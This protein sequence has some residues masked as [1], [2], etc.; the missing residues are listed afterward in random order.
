MSEAFGHLSAQMLLHVLLMNA[1]A[2]SLALALR[3]ATVPAWMRLLAPATVVQVVALWGWHAPPGL[4][5]ALGSAL[6]HAAM[7]ASLFLCA[8]WFWLAVFS[9]EARW[10]AILALLVTGKLFCLMGV[11]LVF[12]PRTLYPGLASG[13]HAATLADQQLAGLLMLAACP[14]TYVVAGVVIAARWLARLDRAAATSSASPHAQHP[15]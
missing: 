7:Q 13:T 15:A 11:L 4:D 8:L 9:A 1:A 12:A 6:L 10:R 14:A 3:G 5:A 2:P